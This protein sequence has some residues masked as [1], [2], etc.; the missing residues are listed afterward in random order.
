[1]EGKY[2]LKMTIEQVAEMLQLGRSTLY[3]KINDGSL[4]SAKATSG[5][6]VLYHRDEVL[7]WYFC[8]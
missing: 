5:Q 3:R 4:E 6:R 7:K 2:P 8:R 1:M